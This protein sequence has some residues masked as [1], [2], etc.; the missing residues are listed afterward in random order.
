MTDEAANATPSAS[1]LE[2]ARFTAVGASGYVVNLAVFAVVIHA[3]GHYRVAA[4]VAFLVAVANNFWWHRS[5]TFA[6]RHGHPARQGARF[7]VVSV[8]GFL[9]SLAGLSILVEDFHTPEILAQLL[10]TGAWVPLSYLC[11]RFWAF[12]LERAQRSST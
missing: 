9:F 10:A 6:V 3:G 4:T 5:W 8:A 2:L 7:F 12:E 1:W 11:N